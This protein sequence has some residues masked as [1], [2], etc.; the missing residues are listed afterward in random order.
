M[1]EIWLFSDYKSERKLDHSIFRKE[2]DKRVALRQSELQQTYWRLTRTDY[3]TEIFNNVA[4]LSG[5]N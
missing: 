4:T 1:T 3:S 5:I 2:K